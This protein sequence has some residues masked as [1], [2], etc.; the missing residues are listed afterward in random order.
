MTFN[1]TQPE[2]PAAPLVSPSGAHASSLVKTQICIGCGSQT[3]C[4]IY[5]YFDGGEYMICCTTT[6]NYWGLSYSVSC[7]TFDGIIGYTGSGSPIYSVANISVTTNNTSVTFHVPNGTYW[8][9]I[10]GPPGQLVSGI[11]PSGNITVSGANVTKS[12]DLVSGKTVD[13]LYVEKGLI[14]G[15]TWCVNFFGLCSTTTKIASENLSLTPGTYPFWVGAV[16][17]YTASTQVNGQKYGSFGWVTLNARKTTISVQFTPPLYAVTFNE[18]GLATGIT[19][20]LRATCADSRENTSGCGGMAAKGSDEAS[21]TGGTITLM[22]RN[23]TYTWKIT[24]I[25][26][27]ELEFGGVVDP[28]WSGSIT[29]AA[30]GANSLNVF[31]QR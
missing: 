2:Q 28:T 9:M 14:A 15:T 30:R 27:Y 10:H 12:Y 21:S 5:T 19:W 4:N 20:H 24:P 13:L 23:G 8:Y 16:A 31:F 18:T 22:L 7:E 26:G 1:L 29:V 17:G 6:W 11:A 3:V 25:K